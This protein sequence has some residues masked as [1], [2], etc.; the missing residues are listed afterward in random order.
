MY[1]LGAQQEILENESISLLDIKQAL[2]TFYI[3]FFQYMKVYKRA[4]ICLENDLY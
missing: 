1:S 2:I 4:I 3:H